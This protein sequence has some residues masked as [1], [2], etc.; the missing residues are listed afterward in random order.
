MYR[1]YHFNGCLI[2]HE[3]DVISH[4]EYGLGLVID[5]QVTIGLSFSRDL[6]KYPIVEASVSE[7]GGTRT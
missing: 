1:D 4:D 3:C 7:S 2:K 6:L 5:A